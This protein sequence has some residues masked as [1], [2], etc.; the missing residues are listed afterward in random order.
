M[1]EKGGHKGQGY[2]SLA[3]LVL[4]YLVC[5]VRYH[6]GRPGATILATLSHFLTFAPF[7]AGGTLIVVRVF[8]GFA[9]VNPPAVVVVRLF[10]TIG[11]IAEL[12]AG[13]YHYLKYAGA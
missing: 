13:I 6:P 10:L 7:L 8:R 11:L 1:R 2:L 5:L 4:V 12:F 9:G 3:V